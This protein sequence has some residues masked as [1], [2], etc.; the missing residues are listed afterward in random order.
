MNKKILAMI[1][2]LQSRLNYQEKFINPAVHRS[3]ERL[4][5]LLDISLENKSSIDKVLCDHR[6]RLLDLETRESARDIKRL[7]RLELRI[8]SLEK[9]D[10]KKY[11]IKVEGLGSAWTDDT[12]LSRFLDFWMGKNEFD[13]FKFTC[14]FIVPRDTTRPLTI[15]RI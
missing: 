14:G 1:E 5:K 11:L 6:K 7:E 13:A 8:E 2:A 3:R 4:D 15:E 9:S 12:G 10:S